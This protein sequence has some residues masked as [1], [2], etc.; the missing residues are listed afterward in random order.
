[1]PPIIL[2]LSP[3]LNEI[4][5]K[6]DGGGGVVLYRKMRLSLSNC[7]KSAGG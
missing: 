4:A 1:M 5:Q 6:Y 3:S 2:S 7:H